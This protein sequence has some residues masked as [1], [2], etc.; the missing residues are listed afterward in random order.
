MSLCYAPPVSKVSPASLMNLS[1]LEKRP[2][3]REILRE[4]GG[5]FLKDF[6]HANLKNLSQ[7]TETRKREF[8]SV[9]QEILSERLGESVASAAVAQ[10]DRYYGASSADHHGSINSSLA[11]SSNLML[12]SGYE[13]FQDPLIQFLPVLSCASVSLNNDDYPRGLLFHASGDFSLQKLSLLPSNS[14]NCLV[15]NFR[16]YVLEEVIKLEGVLRQ[17]VRK[18]IVNAG[19]AAK[20]QDLLVH[21]YKRPEILGAKDLCEQFTKINYHLWRDYFHNS[22]SVKDLLYIELEELVRRLLICYHLEATTFFQH[23][24]FDDSLETSL[25]K[26]LRQAMEHFMQPGVSTHLFWGVS[27]KNYR[28]KLTLKEG[29]LV[30][31][32]GDFSLSFTPESVKQALLEKKLMPNLLTTYAL[33]HLYYSF[34]CLG[35]F[36]QIHYLDAMQSVYNA[37]GLD[38]EKTKANSRLYHFGLETVFLNASTPAL[39]ADLYFY[40]NKNTWMDLQATYSR[41]TLEEAFRHSASIVYDLLN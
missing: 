13:V 25:R 16:P 20:F 7:P 34:N 19:E 24:L 8:L 26:P 30:S 17:K 36:N 32:E 39:G 41:V 2:L 9:I 3:L 33:I 11:V 15:Y 28:L 6:V 18:G 31:E 12:A 38:E 40:G 4:R 29:Y 10:L 21:V 14:H 22:E 23:F 1:F 5:E 37:S 35:G 27:S